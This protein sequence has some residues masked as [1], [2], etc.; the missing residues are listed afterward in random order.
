MEQEQTQQA[1]QKSAYDEKR[2]QREDEAKRFQRKKKLK[3]ILIWS[4]VIAILG[5]LIQYTIKASRQ[6]AR[7]QS[8]ND[9]VA[10]VQGD[11]FKAQS[12]DHIK[13]GDKHDAYNSNPPTGGWHYPEPAPTGVYTHEIDDETLIHNLEHGHIWIS[14][15]PDLDPAVVQKLKDIAYRFHSKIIMAPRAKNDSPIALGAWEYLLKLDTYDE[16][17][18]LGFIKAHRGKG[19][20]DVPDTGF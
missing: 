2:R 11:F 8:Q 12:R 5:L 14:Y 1:N 20:E 10:E 6:A 9:Q 3:K 16:A 18:I 15:K 13:P 19:P 7:V 17:K 4:F